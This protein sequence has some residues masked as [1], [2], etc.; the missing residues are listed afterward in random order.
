M[1]SRIR[2]YFAAI[3][4]LLLSAVTLTAGT[5]SGGSGTEEDPYQINTA[6]DLIELGQTTDD[7]DKHF[8]LT[9]DIDMS[10]Y[11]FSTAV[12]APDTDEVVDGFQGT[13]FKGVFDGGGHSIL[14]LT[15]RGSSY[16]GLF[17]KTEIPA[18]IFN[19][20]LDDLDVQGTSRY[21]G[22]LVG[23]NSANI[24]AIY[25]AGAVTG[26]HTYYVGGLVGENF[27]PVTRC[28]ST[29]MVKGHQYVGGLMGRNGAAI[30]AGYSTAAVTGGYHVGGLVGQNYSCIITG[31]WS[32]GTVTGY[33]HVG[34]LIGELSGHIIACYSTVTDNVTGVDYVG[35]LVGYTSGCITA[36]YSMRA[37]TGNR[38]VG[39]L[40]GYNLGGDIMGS[41][42]MGPV[43]GDSDGNCIGGLVG[44]SVSGNIT[45]SYSTG[46][47]TG[48]RYVGGL[49]GRNWDRNVITAS[50]SIGAVAGNRWVGGLVGDNWESDIVFTYSTGTVTSSLNVGGLVGD[51]RAQECQWV[52]D[53]WDCWEECIPVQAPWLV[54]CSF[55]DKLASNQSTSAGGLGRM[56]SQMK[57]LSTFMAAG[58]DFVDE[59]ANGSKDIWRMCADGVDYP[60]L[61][62][63]FSRGGDLTCPDGTE[64]QD[65][66]YL[67]DHW[68][69]MTPETIGAADADG[70]GKVT[71]L[72]YAILSENWLKMPMQVQSGMDQGSGCRPHG[73]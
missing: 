63:E 21:I 11:N 22:G 49:V 17:G 72:D 12:I 13:A 8:T 28:A 7:Y 47:V 1:K 31:S 33:N 52:C 64:V 6:E 44:Y 40:V 10:T 73:P 62:W 43:T 18:S 25:S 29:G 58:W 46:S 24:T 39:G 54:E 2:F 14:D 59:E 23:R 34:G 67:A 60:R 37:T 19:L 20:N 35:G 70:D 26:D 9:S 27:G 4:G 50:Y 30:T 36:S 48:D 68:Q 61:A 32:E 51:S 56:T 5:Y 38:F 53:E 65:L 15:I 55:W 16:L 41:Y 69:K 42:S 57:T 71:L 3:A 66:L 45:A